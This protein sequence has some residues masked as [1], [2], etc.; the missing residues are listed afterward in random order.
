[1]IMLFNT[2]VVCFCTET[3]DAWDPGDSRTE[4]EIGDKLGQGNYGSVFRGQVTV[5]AMSRSQDLCC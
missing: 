2:L 1:M 4:I 5:T 3:E